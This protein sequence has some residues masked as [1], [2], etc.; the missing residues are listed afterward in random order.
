MGVWLQVVGVLLQGGEPV[1]GV[2]LWWSGTDIEAVSDST[3]RFILGAPPTFPIWLR[4]GGLIDSLK[5]EQLPESLLVWD[6]APHV[7]APSQPIVAQKEGLQT[8]NPQPIVLWSRTTLTA[9]P[10]CN[11]SEAF[12]GTALVD[13]T[14]SDGALGVRQ[15][16]LLG[17]ETAH[18]PL[19]Y[20]N[21]PLSMG[22]YRPWAVQFTPA[23]WV[24]SLS[25][26][27]GIGSVINGPD[28]IAGQVQVQYLSSNQ[29][30]Y[31]RSVEAFVRSTGELFLAGRYEW[32]TTPQNRYLLLSNLGWT[33]FQSY[34][35]QDHNGDGFLDI[36]LFQHG[37]VLIRH[38]RQDTAGRMLE[39][40]GEGLYDYRWA[41][42]VR[43]RRPEDIATLQAWGSYQ[44][45][46]FLQT[47][48][49]RGWVL[50]RGRGLSLLWQGRYFSQ[51]L[52][53]GFNQYEAQQPLGW[54]QLIY[55]QP[56]GDTRWILQAGPSVRVAYYS[57]SL[58]TWHAYDTSWR[59]IEGIAGA[60]TEVI[61]SPYPTLSVVLGGRAD[62]HSFW[63]WQLLPRL[64][65]RWAYAERGALRL[66]AGRAWRIPDPLSE[67]FPFLLSMRLWRL[68][69]GRWPPVESGW[70]YGFFW[71]HIFGVGS[72][73][74]RLSLDGLRAHFRR[75]LIWNIE[76][77]WLVEV[78]SGEKPAL[79]QA[80]YGELQYEIPDQL[81]FTLGYKLQ[82]VWWV[83][84]GHRVF[85]PL[86]PRHRVVGWLT[87]MTLSRRWQADAILSWYG[88]QR[89]PSTAEKEEPYRLSSYTPAF[90][91]IALQITHRVDQWEIQVAGENLG[92][93]RQPQ[94]VL[95][96][97]QPFSPQFDAS[98]VWG[99]IM[100]RMASISLR[101]NW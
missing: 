63:G 6:I 99:P 101:Y 28:G 87:W 14:V 98:L 60:F 42:Q 55:R 32:T 79:Y 78:L 82:E 71:H 35:L 80:L 17:F 3:G 31:P 95:A 88:R 90:A 15:L 29:P 5:L 8:L 2:R 50:S 49:R 57:E 45:L 72:H 9:A 36:P 76:K 13:A 65:L 89:L 56:L 34:A 20:E 68:N 70:S 74:L 96:A 97:D 93:F 66:S 77:P 24:Q 85:R 58:S 38:V 30:D 27:K 100:G 21:K 23:L 16:R 69:L 40:D 33:P 7:S 54:A 86:L 46:Y 75:P 53:A 39:I 52:Q 19:L 61:G 37:H 22:L 51:H 62:W 1:R 10:C 18:S 92:G 11:L 44:R 94:P 84:S 4:A 47:S 64:H 91:T 43:F 26:T 59:R 81:R 41:G 83:L 67:T 73:I 48:L 25:V 12:E